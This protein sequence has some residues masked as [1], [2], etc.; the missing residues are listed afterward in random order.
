MTYP[1]L[2]AFLFSAVAAHKNAGIS[3]RLN[4]FF[5][6]SSLSQ[7]LPDAQP[8]SGAAIS[9]ARAK[10]DY[11]A[12]QDMFN[13][14]VNVAQRLIP[15]DDSHLW[16]GLYRVIAL[17]GSKYT[18]PHSLDII[19]ALDPDAGLH[20]NGKG[21]FPQCLVMTAYDVLAEYPLEIEILPSA[22]SERAIAQK[23]LPALPSKAILL[24]DR[25][26]PSFKYMHYLHNEYNGY[27]V[28]RC[29]SKETFPAV[30][31]FISKGA[32]EQVIS[33][34]PTLSYMSE[35]SPQ[36]RIDAAPIK[37]RAIRI[38]NGDGSVSV[39]LTNM[40]D[41]DTFTYNDI[42]DLYYKRW[43]VEVH[44]RNDKCILEIE[45][46]HSRSTNGIKQEIYCAAIVSVIA[47]IVTHTE[48]EKPEPQFKN[49]VMCFAMY[50]AFLVSDNAQVAHTIFSRLLE[51]VQR[52]RYH[53]HKFQR[54]SQPR[55]CKKPPNKW[56]L[57]NR[58]QLPVPPCKA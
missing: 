31:K 20:N 47:R 40:F 5:A 36:E 37:V 24:H 43:P 23:I 32:K 7:L 51:D 22:T 12:F 44:Y 13:K 46:F 53:K 28:F 1:K 25:G 50:A 2:V 34:A 52:V 54:T 8:C 57:K 48:N 17:D 41:T 39:L 14:A 27:Y 49:A 56:A 30:L 42:V 16:K 55:I 33:I 3:I 4:E 58:S 38:D 6:L 45:K 26:F 18:L 35:L 9:T 11:R 15:L 29:P 21:H 19:D 10:I